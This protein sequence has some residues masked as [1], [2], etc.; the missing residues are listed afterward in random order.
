[1][2]SEVY[3]NG[4][5]CTAAEALVSV[6]DR[7]FLFGDGVYEAIRCFDG[8]LFKLEEHLV[9]LQHSAAKILLELPHSAA[10]LTA[11]CR[12]LLSR[13]GVQ[14]GMIY[15]QVTRGAAP[16]THQFPHKVHPTFL[17]KIMETDEAILQEHRR[18]VK[19][20]FRPDDRWGHC[21]IKSVSLLPNVLAREAATRQ[22]AYEAIFVHALGITECGSSN[23]FIVRD[24]SLIT[25]P[26]GDRI[27]PGIIRETVLQ[28]AAA[29]GLP[30]ELRYP[31]QEEAVTADEVF[32][33]NSIDEIA[34]VL[35]IDEKTVA[36]GKPGKITMLLQERLETLKQTI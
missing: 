34:P 9:R 10:Q 13:G 21:D 14:N 11:I 25:A 6:D 23:L 15:L 4:R 16:R 29:A 17:A 5:Y 30:V 33:T 7:G 27:L 28:L 3:L 2:K 22:G 36:E 18:G 24:G 35:A 8:K 32:I 31:R 19:A 20:I 26:D 1:M 12:E